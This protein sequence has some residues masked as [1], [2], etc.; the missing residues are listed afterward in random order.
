MIVSLYGMAGIGKTTFANK[1]FQD[2]FIVSRYSRLVFVTVGPKY[3]LADILVDILTQVN[4]NNIDEEEIMEGKHVL[5]ELK[6]RVY[7]SLESSRYLIV[8]DDIWDKELCY[9]LLNLFPDNENGSRVLLT[10]RICRVAESVKKIAENCEGLPLTLVIV[11]D[12]L[13][14][15]DRTLEYWNN[16]ADDKQHSVYKDA[17]DQM[18]KVLYPSYDYLEQH[19]KACFLYVG[20]FPQNYLVYVFDLIDLLSAEGF[21]NPEPI[22]NVD[23][24]AT[25]KNGTYAYTYELRSKNVI[26]FDKEA[27]GYHLHSSLWYLCNKEAAKTKLFYALNCRADALPEEGTKYHRRLCIR[28]SILF[29]IEDVHNSIAFASNVRSLLCTG[30]FHEY[31][32]PLP[33]EHLRLLRVLE[34]L[35]IR[36]YEFPI[37]VVK[38]VQLRYF[39][40]FYDGNLPTSISKLWNLQH[41]IIHQFSNIKS[42]GNASYMPDE[43]WNMNELKC[44]RI[45]G[46]NLP[47][48]CEGSLLPNLLKLSGVGPKSCTKDVFEKI[49]NLKELVITIEVA[50]NATEGM[51][52]FDHIS[53]LHELEVLECYIMNPILKTNVVTPLAPLSDFPSSLTTL[54]LGG[55]GYTWEEMSK[56]SVITK[57]YISQ[58]GIICLSR[59][60]VGSS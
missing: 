29:A 50:P 9:E 46:R 32:V 38:L 6:R 47:H 20:A 22:H 17:Y 2:P 49:P 39:A 30:P 10:S 25:F 59:P 7:E 14:N 42:V 13:S 58:I 24:N 15:T 16:V 36:F 35:S 41:L 53:H 18:S 19:L 26:M 28:N 5:N 23:P 12:I 54:I 31:P 57:S 52:C 40:L 27:R 55:L 3:R 11:A 43:I 1:L 33:L 21:L 56:I 48:P 45:R 51:G 4:Y 44:L 37:E 8:L 60:K 34:A